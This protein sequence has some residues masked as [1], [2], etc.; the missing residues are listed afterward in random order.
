LAH[1][2]DLVYLASGLQ[3]SGVYS[4]TIDTLL[5]KINAREVFYDVRF[6]G[7]GKIRDALEQTLLHTTIMY[8]VEGQ[9][10]DLG[11]LFFGSGMLVT[12]FCEQMARNYAI[13]LIIIST[14]KGC[15]V[16]HGGLFTHLTADGITLKHDTLGEVVFIVSLLQGMSTKSLPVEDARRGLALW[17][18][19]C[20]STQL[21]D[22]LLVRLS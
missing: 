6:F 16:C 7:D 10:A 1:S 15:T 18:D 11:V 20:L 2:Y 4:E 22:E 12:P 14:Q 21:S 5:E 13:P 19:A 8:A 9:I 17:P 3:R